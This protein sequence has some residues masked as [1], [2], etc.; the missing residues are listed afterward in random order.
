MNRCSR[1]WDQRTRNPINPIEVA[2]YS[3][4]GALQRCIGTFYLRL[5]AVFDQHV[6]EG[7]EQEVGVG[8][9]ED[10]RRLDLEDVVIGARSEEH[11]S[12]LQSRQY[13]VC[14]LLL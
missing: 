4:V 5:R 11:T 8:G 13:L 10:E 2:E 9:G 6:V 14:R 3:N 12:E 7:G 1:C